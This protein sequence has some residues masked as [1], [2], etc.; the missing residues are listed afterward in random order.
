M[1]V[2]FTTPELSQMSPAWGYKLAALNC[3]SAGLVISSPS[4]NTFTYTYILHM[5]QLG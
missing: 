4:A 3:Q 1:N 5:D 2:L